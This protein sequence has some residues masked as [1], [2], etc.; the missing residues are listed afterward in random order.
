MNIFFCINFYKVAVES[1]FIL[2]SRLLWQLSDSITSDQCKL[3]METRKY[4]AKL[5]AASGLFP[6]PIER[7]LLLLE[8]SYVSGQ[9][10]Y[11]K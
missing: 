1:T 7:V 11:A 3:R 4:A 6:L 5:A 9:L 8:C 10:N 2:P